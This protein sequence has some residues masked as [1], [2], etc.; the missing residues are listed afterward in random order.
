MVIKL[1]DL[2]KKIKPAKSVL[3][4]SGQRLS[5]FNRLK[6]LALDLLF[7]VECLSCG[8]ENAW[9]CT[10]CSR[11]IKFTL[12]DKCLVCKKPAIYGQIH[13]KCRKKTKLDG[14]IMAVSQ[15]DQLLHKL[16]YKF[17]YNFIQ[18][19][20]SPLAEVLTS[21][22]KQLKQKED[23][24]AITGL[25][26]DDLIIVPVPLHKRRLK[27]RG[28]NQAELLAKKI[29]GAFDLRFNNQIL[30]RLKNTKAQIKLKKRKRLKN[31]KG[32]FAITSQF[33]NKLKSAEILL[34]D[35][36]LTTGATMDECARVLKKNGADKVWGAVLTRG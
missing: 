7:P 25:L 9:L 28:F 35:D 22:I 27:W 26:F 17:K 36:I 11:K 32:A 15:D 33:R 12:V 13:Q 31:I 10:V 4:P 14:T 8:R 20:S 19:L 1:P 16:I 30:E 34:I 18:D 5:R 21:K 3:I 24:S 6:S 23:W 2:V 29:T